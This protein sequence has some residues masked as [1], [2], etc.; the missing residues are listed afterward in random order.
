[1]LVNYCRQRRSL[2]VT[3]PRFWHM[4]T[5]M[6]F[7]LILLDLRKPTTRKFTN[8][9]TILMNDVI[10]LHVWTLLA[11]P[12]VH[13][14]HR[15]KLF[16]QCSS[17]LPKT[18]PVNWSLDSGNAFEITAM[19]IQVDTTWTVSIR[20]KRIGQQW[21]GGPSFQLRPIK[22]GASCPDLPFDAQHFVMFRISANTARGILMRFY[23]LLVV[24]R[25]PVLF[26]IMSETYTRWALITLARNFARIIEFMW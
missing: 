10:S 13:K 17:I 5:S 7:W 15:M 22:T 9:S 26:I 4:I 3:R 6:I 18:D 24:N 16:G 25:Q 19:N 2:L 20:T 12:L 8:F 14:K 21:Y 1:M 11:F 23:K